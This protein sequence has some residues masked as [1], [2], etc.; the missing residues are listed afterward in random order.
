MAASAE[1][2]LSGR[3]S[4]G[5]IVTKEGHAPRLLLP[6]GVVVRESAH[7]VPDERGVVAAREIESLLEH[8]DA[9]DLV[10]CLISGGGSA[11]LPA[12]RPGLCL[13][14]LQE[15]TSLLL[16]CG[17][18][19]Q[20]INTVRKHLDRLKGGGLAR[21]ASP[22]CL[23]A[24][25]LS[26]VIGDPLDVIASGPTVPDPTTFADALA[27]LDG[28]GLR[29]KVPPPVREELERGERGEIAETP[30]RGEAIFER[31]HT[32][33]IGS[34]LTAAR[35]A[36]LQAEKEG[37]RSLLLTTSLQG[38]ARQAGRFLAAIANQVCASGDPISRPACL[39]AGG[40]TTV[41][42]QGSGLGG[43]NQELA[44]GA[45]EDLAGLPDT[46]LV[47][48]AT[49]GGDGPTDAA[50]AVVT[51]ESAARARQL[52][53]Q[54]AA[55]LANNDSYPFFA[56]LGDLLKPG[57]TQTNVNDLTFLFFP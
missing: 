49:D 56:S 21:T 28:F 24:L 57:P 3:I 31:V 26:D 47:T 9:E 53:L 10:L 22:A 16:A 37:F 2:I 1:E 35:T 27:V 18:D 30:K 5:L 39:I 32:H 17:A 38:E 14:D 46:F 7:P 15:T 19:I 50:G 44:L 51:G 54:P 36:A 12:P 48:L 6:G 4:G 13:A 41:T 40:E 33:L 34:N 45:L 11:L 52:G 29:A 42:L 25:I 55:S 43:R 20:Q 8:A 23:V